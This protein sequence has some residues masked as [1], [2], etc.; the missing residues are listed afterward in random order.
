MPWPDLVPPDRFLFKEGLLTMAIT[1]CA[2]SG[3]PF[4]F[5][6][7]EVWS[8][9]RDSFCHVIEVDLLSTIGKAQP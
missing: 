8:A 7:G 5:D 6:E 1:P 9:I 4:E 2:V 3:T